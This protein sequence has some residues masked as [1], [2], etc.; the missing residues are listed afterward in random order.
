MNL[1]NELVALFV[2]VVDNSIITQKSIS[3]LKKSQIMMVGAPHFE[4]RGF[5]SS[6]RE[7]S[8]AQESIFRSA[9]E[10]WN[11]SDIGLPKHSSVV[12]FVIVSLP[13]DSHV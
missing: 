9:V 10:L 11:S 6:A 8:C 12:N 4:F 13:G 1:L 7:E 2:D 5:L 3:E